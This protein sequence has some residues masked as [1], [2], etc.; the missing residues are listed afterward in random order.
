VHR[1]AACSKNREC[2]AGDAYAL[3]ARS[4]APKRQE[5]VV[6][7]GGVPVALDGVVKPLPGW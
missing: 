7:F 5:I 3:T 2:A 4:R 1:D 6:R